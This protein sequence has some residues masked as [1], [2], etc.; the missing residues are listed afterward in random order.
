MEKIF[1]LMSYHE[2]FEVFFKILNLFKDILKYER[3]AAASSLHSET[4]GAAIFTEIDCCNDT[5][6]HTV[7]LE[8]LL[9]SLYDADSSLAQ[10][11]ASPEGFPQYVYPLASSGEVHRTA[12]GFLCPFL[13]ASLALDSFFE[14]LCSIYLEQTVVFVSDN[15]NILTSSM[16]FPC[17]F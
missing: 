8:P 2:H 1:C 3:M 17:S 7:K 14:V 9:L 11:A 5:L 16:Y 4:C 15:L 12:A 10:V 6:E 13:F